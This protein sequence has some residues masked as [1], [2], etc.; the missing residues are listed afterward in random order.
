MLDIDKLYEQ[1]ELAGLSTVVDGVLPF[2]TNRSD[3]KTEPETVTIFSSTNLVWLI[4][5]PKKPSL[6]RIKVPEAA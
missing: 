4:N 1:L 2:S 6:K 3:Q 5:M